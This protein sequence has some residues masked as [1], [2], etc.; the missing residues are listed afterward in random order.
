MLQVAVVYRMRTRRI[1][2]FRDFRIFV[3][4]KS[5]TGERQ[6]REEK[7]GA[8]GIQECV[9]VSKGSEEEYVVE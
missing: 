8:G 7:G 2:I 1:V 5:V 3:T 4:A 6:K 9:E